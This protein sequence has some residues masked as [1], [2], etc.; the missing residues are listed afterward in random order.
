MNMSQ[1]DI[2]QSHNIHYINDL[3]K[4]TEEYSKYAN[5]LFDDLIVPH[6]LYYLKTE[7]LPS[8]NNNC[9]DGKCINDNVFN[10]LFQL[11]SINNNNNNKLPKTRRHKKIKLRMTKK[12]K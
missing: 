12:S 10:S 3:F 5:K 8:N 4:N 7:N 9:Q 6:G 1:I 2:E 11:A